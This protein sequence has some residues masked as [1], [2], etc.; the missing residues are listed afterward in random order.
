TKVGVGTWTLTNQNTYTGTTTVSGG[1][2]LLSGTG[3]INGSAKVAV[4][5]GELAVNSSVVLTPM[6]TVDAGGALT[7]SGTLGGTVEFDDATGTVSGGG[8]G[9]AGTLTFTDAQ[10]WDDFT[11]LWDILGADQYDV[12]DITHTDGLQ[13]IGDNYTLTVNN[14]NM[15]AVDH[16]TILSGLASGF[17]A[18]NWSITSGYELSL[19]GTDLV[20][21]TIPEP[22]TWLLLGTGAALLV[23]LRRRR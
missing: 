3:S 21:N 6:V 8:L 2:L 20:L 23:F 19:N 12:L 13:L 9:T 5:G 4:S 16:L 18:D 1:V 15:V 22:S 7:G 17:N 14:P 10:Y 11:Y